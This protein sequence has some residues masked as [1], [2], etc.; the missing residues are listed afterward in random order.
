MQYSEI[1]KLLLASLL[2]VSAFPATIEQ[3]KK[4]VEDAERQGLILSTEAQR[5][6]WVKSNF[7]TDDTEALAAR[8]DERAINAGVI[9]AKEAAKYKS[10]A[11]PEDL[12]RKMLLLR[13]A[14]TIATP[15]N[16]KESEELTKIVASMEGTYGKGK[17]CPQPDKCLSL[18]DLEKILAESRDP[19]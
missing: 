9:W 2:A 1:V 17:Y 18:G 15:A 8:A 6:D 11:L 3:A 5:A 4:F 13:N 16:P 12:E 10:T 19:Q 14:L 7:I